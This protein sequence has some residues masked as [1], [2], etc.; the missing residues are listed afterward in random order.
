MVKKTD[1]LYFIREMKDHQ[2]LYSENDFW[3]P[4]RD[5]TCNLLMTGETL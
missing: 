5:Q 4:D 2:A 1:V 3:A